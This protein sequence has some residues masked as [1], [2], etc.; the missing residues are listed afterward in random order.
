M[1]AFL[2][3][4]SQHKN[5]LKD[6]VLTMEEK[7][8]KKGKKLSWL[9]YAKRTQTR[10]YAFFRRK[11]IRQKTLED[12]LEAVYKKHPESGKNFIADML[13]ELINLKEKDVLHLESLLAI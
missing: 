2:Y 6:I 5:L 7:L 13:S 11:M 12:I 10:G 1:V 3:S 9:S 8:R 4:Y